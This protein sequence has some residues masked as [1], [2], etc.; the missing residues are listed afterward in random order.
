MSGLR[1]GDAFGERFLVGEPEEVT[2]D[3]IANRELPSGLWP[4]TDDTAQ[5]HALTE[6][7]LLRGEVVQDEL[8][9]VF[10]E[11]FLCDPARGYGQGARELLLRIALGEDWRTLTAAAFGGMGSMGNGA[12]MRVAPLGAYFCS[13]LD[14]V[15]QQAVRSAEVSHGNLNAIAGAVGVAI[16][17]AGVATDT[18]DE[19]VWREILARTPPSLTRD[20]LA[21][22]S[23]LPIGTAPTYAADALGSGERLCAHDTVPFCVWIVLTSRRAG[24]EECLWRTVS[25]LGDCD[26]TCAIVGGML[27]ANEGI[28]LPP[29]WLDHAEPIE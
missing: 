19:D 12:A 26:T 11:T 3:R 20:V 4:W 16:A 9:L 10:A 24:F 7:L 28:E 29:T 14:A 21:A 13:D 25:G 2:L 1:L 6:H 18:P 17:T 27:A 22:A 23:Q 15:A 5:A 8:A